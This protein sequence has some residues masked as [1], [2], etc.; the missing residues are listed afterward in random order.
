MS[1][2]TADEARVTITLQ[3]FSGR[4]NPSW[5][6]TA[7]DAE[8][9]LQMLDQARR[10]GARRQSC[11]APDLGYRGLTVRVAAGADIKDWRVFDGCLQQDN[12]HLEDGGRRIEAFVL[13]TMPNPLK[14]ELAPLLP[15]IGN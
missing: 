7:Q 14:T 6:L 13:R 5:Q 11:S 15:H 4:P 9:L 1:K 3:V 2:N 12:K 10:S 8:S